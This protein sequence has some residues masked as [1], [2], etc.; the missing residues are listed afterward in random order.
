MRAALDGDVR[1]P[2]RDAAHRHL[3]HPCLKG[4]TAKW[5]S[6]SGGS[7]KYVRNH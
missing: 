6:A 5:E 1:L 4:F 7:P 2:A 3:E